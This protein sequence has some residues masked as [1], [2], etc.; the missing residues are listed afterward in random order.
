MLSVLL[1]LRGLEN[2]TD[3]LNLDS[4]S[5]LCA[6]GL[7]GC[8]LD[9]TVGRLGDAGWDIEVLSHQ[10]E[11]DIEPALADNEYYAPIIV[12]LQTPNELAAVDHAVVL[13]ELVDSTHGTREAR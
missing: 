3:E 9:V 8:I 11:D 7:L 4:M 5:E 2:P 6:E 13:C 12:T 10:S 1:S